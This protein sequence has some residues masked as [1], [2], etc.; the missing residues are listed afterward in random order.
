MGKHGLAAVI[1]VGPF[2]A[3]GASTS[4]LIVGVISAMA[5]AG[6]SW[7]KGKINENYGEW[8]KWIK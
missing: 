8:N 2:F 1:G 7:P 4:S 5:I 3:K 6:L